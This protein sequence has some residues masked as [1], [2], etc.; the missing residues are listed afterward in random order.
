ML[1]PQRRWV[2]GVSSFTSWDPPQVS[3]LPNSFQGQACIQGITSLIYCCCSTH[4]P[5][6]NYEVCETANN[7]ANCCIVWRSSGQTCA[8]SFSERLLAAARGFCCISVFK[9]QPW[10]DTFAV[11]LS[12]CLL[13]WPNSGKTCTNSGIA[14]FERNW[15]SM[16]PAFFS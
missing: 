11:L 4:A 2:A 9:R 15:P 10:A 5:A 14:W 1:L 6:H 8:L 16:C 3:K 7:W 13:L 12:T